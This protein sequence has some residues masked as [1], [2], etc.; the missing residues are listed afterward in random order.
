MEAAPGQGV[1]A[2][3]GRPPRFNRAG[4]FQSSCARSA[5]SRRPPRRTKKEAQSQRAGSGSAGNWRAR[6][7]ATV[8]ARARQIS[9]GLSDRFGSDEKHPI[10]GVLLV[11]RSGRTLQTGCRSAPRR[12]RDRPGRSLLRS[13]RSRDRPCRFQDRSGR[14]RH[15]R[16]RSRDRSDRFRLR[17]HRSRPRRVD[18]DVALADHE[19]DRQGTES[20]FSL[21]APTSN[22]VDG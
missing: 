6:A 22:A 14:S 15:R 4:R 5:S 12:S 3:P 17:P 1:R 16:C 13:D 20:G 2:P 7:I 10:W 19:V 18:P 11:P 9:F 8:S 21:A